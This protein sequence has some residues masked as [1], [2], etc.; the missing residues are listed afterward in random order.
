MLNLSSSNIP[1]GATVFGDMW[2]D[3]DNPDFSQ[4]KEFPVGTCV[5]KVGNN[6][7]LVENHD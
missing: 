3:P 4:N 7:T 5:F 6:F 1:P 2:K